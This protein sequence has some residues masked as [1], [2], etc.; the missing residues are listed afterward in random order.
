MA[1]GNVL[2]VEGLTKRFGER[3]IFEDLHFGLDRGQ[4]AALVARNGTGKS[5]LMKVLLDIEGADEGTVTFA[6]NVR[7]AHLSQDHG[8]D[9]DR[10]I[11]ANLFQADND[12]M[13]AIRQ[14]EEATQK[15]DADALQNAYDAMDRADAWSYEAQAKEIL[16]KLGLH[17][18]DRFVDGLS[19][20]EKRRVALAK[21]LIEQPDLLLLDE[22]TN[23]LDLG[24]IE[25]LEEFLARAKT[26]LLMVTH[27]R[28]FLEVVCDTILELDNFTLHKYP[29]NWS[30]FLEKK[31]ERSSNEH[32]QRDRAR[33]IMRR[34]LEWV[35]ATPQARTGKSKSRL[36]AFKGLKSR[37]SVRLEEDEVNLELDP[38]RM[39]GKILEMHKVSRAY[40]E[41]VI[42]KGWTYHFKPGERVG[43]VGDNG[44]GKSTLI[45]LMTGE[46]KPDGGKVVIG[47]TVVFG[48]FSQEPPSFDEGMKVIE[49]LYEI[50]QYMPLKKG[51][52]L[53]AAQLLERFLFPRHRHHDFIHKLSGGERKRLHLLR[54]LMGNP[55][56]LVF[57]EPTNDLDVFTLGV[58][59][60]FLLDFPGC[61]LL[62]SH[63][64]YF[65]DK[66]VDHVF[67][68]DGE[69]GVRD[70]PGNYT[71]YR[72]KA[73]I[74]EQVLATQQATAAKEAARQSAENAPAAPKGDYSKRLSYNEQR[75]YDGLE[76]VI[77]TLEAEKS[78]LETAM[79]VASLDHEELSRLATRL[80]EVST[81]IEAKTERWIELDERA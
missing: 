27:D 78:E 70:F 38:A 52:K 80:G 3:L 40:G 24:M 41:K 22:P 55:N 47:D 73:D 20:G 46:D 15:E 77:A 81:D 54:V 23:H 16:G 57:D 33:S 42:L 17:D 5:T 8:L 69:G 50:A 29:G 36:D 59:E 35:R 11:L 62:V 61:L 2:S 56:F 12:A 51:Q 65:M 79:A 32:A 64:R 31:T 30:Y 19:G 21:C 49:A 45:R 60:E 26:T 10:T 48:H 58:L 28:F 76:G 4:K 63:D 25:W 14:Y 68:L 6:G 66:L 75:E 72:T 74:E 39:G 53:S 34:E 13:R 1:G 67:V 7:I 71:Q 44:A 18:T 37:A 9:L 43:L